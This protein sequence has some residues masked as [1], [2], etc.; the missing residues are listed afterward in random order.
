ML[1][2]FPLPL[3]PRRLFDRVD[4]RAHPP[5]L[6]GADAARSRVFERTRNVLWR[7]EEMGATTE[8]APRD[9]YLSENVATGIVLR[10][11]GLEERSD[12]GQAPHTPRTILRSWYSR[13]VPPP[14]TRTSRVPAIR[15]PDLE[16]CREAAMHRQKNFLT[17]HTSLRAWLT[18]RNAMVNLCLHTSASL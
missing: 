3:C 8:H 17:E 7:R 4:H 18:S 14:T 5:T 2:C 1:H 11:L 6:R 10:S 9:R 12:I 16:G 15:K 13:P